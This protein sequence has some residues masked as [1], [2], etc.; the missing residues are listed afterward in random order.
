[1]NDVKD[2]KEGESKKEVAGQFGLYA[3][4][5]IITTGIN[6]GGQFIFNFFML[7][8]IAIALALALGYTTKF[9]LD[10]YITFR[11]QKTEE[12]NVKLQFIVYLIIAFVFYFLNLTLQLVFLEISKVFFVDEILQWLFSL[13][14]SLMIVF[15]IKFFVDK[16]FVFKVIGQKR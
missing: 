5:A 7:L 4:F 6:I 3:I 9:F 1:M 2:T 11:K 16:Y 12:T 10:C 14:A 8:Q 13:G 15:G